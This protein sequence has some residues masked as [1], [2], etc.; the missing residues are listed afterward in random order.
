MILSGSFHGNVLE[1]VITME[2]TTAV[3]TLRPRALPFFPILV[4]QYVR[5]RNWSMDEC[6]LQL[7]SGGSQMFQCQRISGLFSEATALNSR[8]PYVRSGGQ[9]RSNGT[10]KTPGDRIGGPNLACG[11]FLSV[12]LDNGKSP[13]P[14]E[15]QV[16]PVPPDLE[17][18]ESRVGSM[19]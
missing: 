13:P 4:L 3:L 17:T 2:P 12:W 19:T 5:R 7:H 14:L 16:D 11:L 9:P 10:Q 15:I 18:R 6:M 8:R 1:G